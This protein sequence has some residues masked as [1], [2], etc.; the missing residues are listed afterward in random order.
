MKKYSLSL[1]FASSLLVFQVHSAE[2][3][4]SKV[5]D[6]VKDGAAAAETFVRQIVEEVKKGSEKPQVEAAADPASLVSYKGV[7]LQQIPV[8]KQGENNDGDASC[9]YHSLKN[10]IAVLTNNNDLLSGNS[11]FIQRNFGVDPVGDWR[12][13][14]QVQQ[15]DNGEWI[16]TEY[17]DQLIDQEFRKRNLTVPYSLINSQGMAVNTTH[18][19]QDLFDALRMLR[20]DERYKHVFFVNTATGNEVGHHGHWYLVIMDKQADGNTNYLVMDSLNPRRVVDS[21]TADA[22]LQLILSKLHGEEVSGVLSRDPEVPLE[23]PEAS[24]DK[25]EDLR[26]LFLDLVK[27]YPSVDRKQQAV[28]CGMCAKIIQGWAKQGFV[29]SGVHLD[30]ELQEAVTRLEQLVHASMAEIGQ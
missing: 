16:E 30:P 27:K 11:A 5:K 4:W 24:S 14:I 29:Q 20:P 28:I 25:Q 26:Q 3:L 18:V 9:G 10:A 15:G 17:L 19:G 1:L 21:K 13:Q 22:T 6:A 2:G 23:N 12:R 8:T 7:A